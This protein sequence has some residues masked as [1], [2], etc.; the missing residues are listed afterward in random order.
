MVQIENVTFGYRR[1][2]PL[3]EGLGVSLAAGRIYGLFGENG[4]GKTT[5]LK[6][7]CG[8]LLPRGGRVA[9]GGADVG[10]R[11]FGALSGLFLIPEEFDL[12]QMRTDDFVRANAGFYPNFSRA[13]FDELAAEFGLPAGADIHGL[14]FGQ[15]KKFLISFALACNT[16]LLL[17]DEPTNALDI[18]SKSQFRKVM[19]RA[20]SEERCVVIST[21]QVRDLATVIDHAL[22]LTR[23]RL[24]M[25][26]SLAEIDSR[27]AFANVPDGYA[28]PVLYSEPLLSGR[29]IIAPAGSGAPAGQLDLELLFNGML[30]DAGSVNKAFDSETE[31]NS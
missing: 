16:R 12:P 8:L 20:A 2:R 3:F 24:I 17:M 30:A 27:L 31:K 11:G 13:Q 22:F 18:P 23:G 19:A 21:H 5:L 14:S 28:G 6:L 15:K 10:R 26:R 9:V 25:D 29:Q 7:M 4:A 1:G